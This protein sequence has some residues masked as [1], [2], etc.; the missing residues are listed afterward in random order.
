MGSGKNGTFDIR[1]DFQQWAVMVFWKAENEIEEHNIQKATRDLFGKFI[2]EW[3]AFFNTQC[4]IFYLQPYAGHGSWD[5]E[6]FIQQKEKKMI[7]LGPLRYLPGQPSGF[8]G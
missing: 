7:Q 4:R 2:I 6:T 3:L 1:P 5:R 8:N